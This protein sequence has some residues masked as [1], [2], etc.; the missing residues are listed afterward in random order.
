[1]AVQIV[2]HAD[3]D[4][5]YASVEQLDNPELKGKPVLVG[6]NPQGR[7]VVAA[8]SYEARKYGVHSAMPM[9]QAV[10]LCPQGIVVA[11]RFRRY[12]EMSGQVMGIFRAITPLVE[13]ISLDEAFLDIT[14][15]VQRGAPLFVAGRD[16]KER[17]KEETGL[18]VSVGIAACKSVAKIASDR[19]KPDGLL[20][21]EPG[22]ERA[23]LAPLPVK[24]LWGV[25]PK[26]EERLLQ[27]GIRT[28]GDLA[29]QSESWARERFGKRGPELLALSRGEDDRPVV[30]ERDAKS[31]SAEETFENDISDPEAIAFQL[32][33]L[34]MKVAMRLSKEGVKGKTVTVKLRLAD[35]TTF[36][37]S[38]S[39]PAPV[40]DAAAIQ[41]VAQQLVVKE[42][43][44]GRKF[45]LLGVGVSGFS[46]EGQ[47]P[48]IE[49][50]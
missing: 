45:R 34:C 26:T 46:D 32:S 33:K 22:K 36:T 38:A 17:V 5:F 21:V 14:Y 6:G 40:A 29:R 43:R 23:F 13:P 2:L 39:L 42:L 8:C 18:V 28:L 12:G 24:E 35:F 25:G 37:R 15:L 44:P 31:I 50:G 49:Q 3:M 11:P 10:R 47:L 41:R 48:L 1:M 27:D 20:V 4:A 7:S 9:S 16:L 30:A 19:C